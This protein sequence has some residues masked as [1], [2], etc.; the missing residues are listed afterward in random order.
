MK[1]R[2]TSK[3]VRISARKVRRVINLLRGK[4]VEFALSNLK[5]MPH[6]GARV[7]EKAVMSAV[8]NAKNNFKLDASSLYI[9]EAMVDEAAALKR[10]KA[11]SRG[12]AAPRK[13]RICHVTIAVSP[14][15]ETKVKE[16]AKKVQERKQ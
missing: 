4:R 11:A 6:K 9:S 8:A 1:V 16:T 13:R 3:W 14:M 12:R 5:F 15:E 2:A 10:F 7:I